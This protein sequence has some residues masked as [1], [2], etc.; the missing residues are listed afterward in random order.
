MVTVS[1]DRFSFQFTSV[2]KPSHISLDD[3]LPPKLD[4]IAEWEQVC[5]I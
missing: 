2:L 3:E 4:T 1:L 5:C